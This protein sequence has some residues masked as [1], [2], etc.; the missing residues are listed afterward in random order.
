MAFGD[1]TMELPP[2]F[3]NLSG[4][5]L[6]QLFCNDTSW[7]CIILAIKSPSITGCERQC[8]YNSLTKVC[9]FNERHSCSGLLIIL[10]FNGSSENQPETSLVS[11]NMTVHEILLICVCFSDNN[12]DLYV[13]VYFAHSSHQQVY[14]TES[15]TAKCCF[16]NIM[17]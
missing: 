11:Q 4:C 7:I 5:S 6:F 16:D 2:N 8:C 12:I 3:G 15:L 17:C 9:H 1:A 13:F 10:R 14:L